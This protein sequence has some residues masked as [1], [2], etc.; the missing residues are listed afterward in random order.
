MESSFVDPDTNWILNQLG[1]FFNP[2]SEFESGS[3][4]VKIGQIRGK[5]W[6]I[7]DKNSQFTWLSKQIFTVPLFFLQ[8]WKPWILIQ[9]GQIQWIWIHNTGGKLYLCFF[10]NRR[11]MGE[12]GETGCLG[13]FK[14]LGEIL[15]FNLFKGTTSAPWSSATLELSKLFRTSKGVSVSITWVGVL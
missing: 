3:T 5:M 6:K 10:I 14:V 12:T 13:C 1:T 15:I 8:F 4:Q 2:F 9:K 7:E 11:D